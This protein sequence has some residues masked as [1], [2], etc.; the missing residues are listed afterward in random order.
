MPETLMIIAAI[1]KKRKARKEGK[2]K[3]D[4]VNREDHGIEIGNQVLR[5]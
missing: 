2:E 1:K 5:R 3:E 4:A